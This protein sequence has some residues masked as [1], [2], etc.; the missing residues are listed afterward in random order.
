MHTC[1]MKSSQVSI[2]GTPHG[3]S[4]DRRRHLLRLSKADVQNPN[5]QAGRHSPDC[6]QQMLDMQGFTI[7]CQLVASSSSCIRDRHCEKDYRTRKHILSSNG[8][9]DN[10]NVSPLPLG[11]GE[12]A[13]HK[14]VIHL[15]DGCMLGAKSKKTTNCTSS[16]NP[17]TLTDYLRVSALSLMEGA[18]CF[19]YPCNVGRF[20]GLTIEGDKTATSR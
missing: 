4:A 7:A 17:P 5:L 10:L 9:L 6:H 13:S 12:T 8:C 11:C 15:K 20:F 3:R 18:Q 2:V 19:T 1:S 14:V 16:L